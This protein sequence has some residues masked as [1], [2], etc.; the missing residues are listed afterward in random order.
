[1]QVIRL[2]N[3]P[4]KPASHEDPA[5]VGVLKQILFQKADLAPGKVQMINWSTLLPYKSFRPH[6]HEAMDEVFIIMSGEVEITVGGEKEKLEKGD[7]VVIP[8][9]SIHVMKNLTDQD[10]HYIAIG[11]SRDAGGKTVVVDDTV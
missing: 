4:K 8:E 10:V 9:Q 1:M 7:A 3:L 11:I 2:N 6:Y 5:D